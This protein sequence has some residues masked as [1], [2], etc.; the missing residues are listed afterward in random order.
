MSEITRERIR[1]WMEEQDI[2]ALFVSK[3]INVRYV[4]G[5]T[6]DDAY[7]LLTRTKQF[8]LTD[9]RYT[10]QAS[11]ECLSFTIMEW[12]SIGSV[13][14]AVGKIAKEEGLRRIAFEEDDMVYSFYSQIREASHAELV[15]VSGVIEELR[16]HKTPQEIEYLR[17]SC[18]IASDAF[19]RIIKDIRVGVTEK[20]LAAKLSLYMVMGGSDT[21]PYGNILIS[22]A[23]TSLLHGIPSSKAIEYGDFV[24]MDYG[25][26]YKGYLSDMTRTVVVGKAS[27]RQREVYRLEQDMLQ[28]MEEKML[29][30]ATSAEVYDAGADLLKGTEYYQYHYAGVGHGIGMFV[31]EIPFLGPKHQYVLHENTVM[32]AEPGIYIPGWGGV[33]I[34][35]TLLITK[36]GAEN[37]TPAD[38]E[39]I[40][41]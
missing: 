16:S 6:S 21:K 40:E 37:L 2:D 23:R 24:L 7:L 41:L 12:R 39:L 13:G 10:E 18:Q 35:D 34:E 3:L 38:K 29:P 26:Q 14:S 17:A 19:A 32:T 11:G 15:P 8:F 5:Y 25:C 28:A 4:S 27:A 36:D 9:P 30:G 31:H 22:G 20:E 33:R 1:A